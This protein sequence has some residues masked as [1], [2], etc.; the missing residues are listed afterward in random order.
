MKSVIFSKLLLSFCL[1]AY[2]VPGQAEQSNEKEVKGVVSTVNT[3][4]LTTT[5]K[6]G[7]IWIR[8]Y[9]NSRSAKWDGV[10]NVNVISEKN[11]VWIRQ[12]DGKWKLANKANG[13]LIVDKISSYASE[14]WTRVRLNGKWGIVNKAN[15]ELI[16]EPAHDSIKP[17]PEAD[18]VLVK[19]DGKWRSFNLATREMIVE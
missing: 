11:L 15:G 8:R 2:G 19:Q 17:S 7:L 4:V 9:S 14:E 18:I 5:S 6:T 12:N 1:T 3:D 10:F 16:L 13:E